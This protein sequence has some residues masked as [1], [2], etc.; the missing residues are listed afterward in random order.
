[1]SAL[2][3]EADILIVGINVCYVPIA[4]IHYLFHFYPRHFCS[5]L[6]AP[7]PA[8]STSQGLSSP[9]LRSASGLLQ[10][11]LDCI[12]QKQTFNTLAS[13]SASAASI[14]KKP[15]YHSRLSAMQMLRKSGQPPESARELLGLDHTN[16]AVLLATISPIGVVV[17]R[18][19]VGIAG[20][21]S[22]VKSPAARNAT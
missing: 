12:C 14:E 10:N 9:P 19:P 22:V 2:P 8:V 3:P 17:A 11:R 15:A 4:D 21:P 6:P 1:M 16:P 5:A 18:S 13:N 7:M 20:L